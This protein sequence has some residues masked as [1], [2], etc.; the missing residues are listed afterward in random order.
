MASFFFP[1]GDLELDL[2]AQQH[3]AKKVCIA[4][5]P[6]SPMRRR[7]MSSHS[8][9]SRDHAH[10]EPPEF[11]S[12]VAGHLIQK[13]ASS[14][15]NLSWLPASPAR[16]RKQRPRKSTARH[17]CPR[18]LRFGSP[19]GFARNRRGKEPPDRAARTSPCGA[20]IKSRRRR[21]SSSSRAPSGRSSRR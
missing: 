9:L 18:R 15:P 14:L 6:P 2:R 4:T 17:S 20:A 11:Q 13:T 12:L 8:E 10:F 19:V 7:E 3:V 21:G 5:A 16:K 1:V